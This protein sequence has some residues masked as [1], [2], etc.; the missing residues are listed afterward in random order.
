MCKLFLV[1]ALLPALALSQVRPPSGTSS[2]VSSAG[3]ST[4]GLTAPSFTSTAASGA[5]AF[6]AV[7]GARLKLGT[8]TLTFDGAALAASVG[9]S[10]PSVTT[11]AA[12]GANAV[13]LVSGSKLCFA[14]ATCTQHMLYNSSLYLYGTGLAID[15]TNGLSA[16]V[17]QGYGAPLKVRGHGA[18]G[19]SYVG[20]TFTSYNA[21]TDEAGTIAAFS[22]DDGTTTNLAIK[23][24][25]R[26]V[27]A[28]TDGSGTPGTV[29]IDKP[30]GKA[31]F[32]AAGTTVVITS[33][34]VTT[35]TIPMIQMLSVDATCT[36][37]SAVATAGTLTVTA[38]A[39]CT[40]ITPFGFVLFQ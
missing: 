12:S 29:T 19:A 9:I 33:N 2:A 39:A 13:V 20:L 3:V 34:Q 10:T 7:Q 36:H 17:V 31:A 23:K 40:G 28:S 25:G 30:T 1:L 32:A 35:A 21:I 37:A 16:K 38:N 15:N 14:G 24:G 11:T 4:V 26:L 6:V 5:D 8:A 27:F 18:T 22:P